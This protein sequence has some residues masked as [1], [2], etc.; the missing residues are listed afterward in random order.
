[1]AADQSEIQLRD[2]LSV[3]VEVAG[4]GRPALVLHSGGGP[5]TAGPI[6]AH[7]AAAGHRVTAPT[8]PGFNLTP[9]P[10]DIASVPDL[11]DAY[12]GLM[13]REGL[14]DALLVGSS[15]GAWT[16]A[17]MA[18][19]DAAGRIGALILFDPVGI[20]VPGET[21]ADLAALSPEETAATVF[22]DP[23]P[24]TPDP[25]TVT[26][27]V[28]A[29]EAGDTATLVALGG[30]PYLHDPTLGERLGAIGVP[31]LVVWGASDGLV[32]PAYGRAF[33]AAIPGARFELIADAGHLPYLEQPAASFAA[34]DRFLA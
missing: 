17:E 26:P 16:A 24:F 23:A 18:T 3:P 32:T 8:H 27:E 31:T 9:R 30:D 19:R 14:D 28:E 34:V 7:L 15:L 33:A 11:A 5:L 13:E 2:D 29:T 21:I 20:D 25:A 4:E 22:H 1:M 10:D 6:V 12:L